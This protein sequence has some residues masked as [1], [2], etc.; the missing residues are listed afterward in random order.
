M[1]FNLKKTPIQEKSMTPKPK[2]LW[3]K[4]L[5]PAVWVLVL[6]LDPTA[7]G[8]TGRSSVPDPRTHVIPDSFYTKGRTTG[9]GQAV[10]SDTKNSEPT[11]PAFD[12]RSHYQRRTA[13]VKPA[14]V[15]TP[16]PPTA[17][18]SPDNA[19]AG[20][21]GILIDARG[22]PG[23]K[24]AILPRLISRQTQKVVYDGSFLSESVNEGALYSNAP[25]NHRRLMI[26]ETYRPLV[27]RPLKTLDH[28][29]FVVSEEDALALISLHK[30]SRLLN[31]AK[32]VIQY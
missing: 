20:Y 5:I 28:Q 8:R 2:T 30:R 23:L 10:R 4:I 13:Q 14:P 17:V 29:D 32:V 27:I 1:F 24:R 26:D 12:Y 16:A 11:S 21:T 31:E 19:M 18:P 3:A 15:A 7:E 9:T 22:M 25:E 6:V